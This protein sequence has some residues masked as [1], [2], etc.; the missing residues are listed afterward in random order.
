MSGKISE[1]AA[2]LGS[3][4][5][6]G[7][8]IEVVIGGVNYKMTFEELFSAMVL[9]GFTLADIPQYADQ[10]AAATGLSG[11]GRLWRQTTTGLLGI[12]IT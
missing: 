12:T 2:A 10:A 4:A 9:Q 8:L 3:D 7:S 6:A 5:V 11:T 1:L